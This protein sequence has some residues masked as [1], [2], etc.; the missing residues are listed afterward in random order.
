MGSLLIKSHEGPGLSGRF[1]GV[2]DKIKDMDRLSHILQ[3]A[4]KDYD[5]GLAQGMFVECPA[6]HVSSMFGW[7]CCKEI[8]AF[9]ELKAPAISVNS[10]C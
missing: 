1:A 4:M 3:E 8:M 10:P 5:S 2:Y 6:D 9:L 7:K